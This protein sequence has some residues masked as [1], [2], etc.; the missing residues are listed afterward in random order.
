MDVFLQILLLDKIKNTVLILN[1]Q[2]SSFFSFSD[3]IDIGFFTNVKNNCE[4]NWNLE[5]CHVI[6]HGFLVIFVI[7]NE[8]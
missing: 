1:S 6:R 7:L 5:T 2:L 4:K 8:C 3:F